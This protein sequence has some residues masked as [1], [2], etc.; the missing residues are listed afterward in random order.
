M[1]VKTHHAL[2][3][4][5]NN[6]FTTK[7]NTL[8]IIYVVRD[9]RDVVLS[10]CNHFNFTIEKSI[11]NLFN[12]DFGTFWEDKVNLFKKQRPTTLISSWESHFMSWNRY[13]FDCPKLIIKFEDL[14]YKKEETIKKISGTSKIS[15]NE[16]ANLFKPLELFAFSLPLTNMVS[17]PNVCFSKKLN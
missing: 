16:V 13:G 3:K 15:G 2:V 17:K 11:D 9:P 4:I 14:V 6:S 7:E 12:K 1:F 5:L 8:G 10:M